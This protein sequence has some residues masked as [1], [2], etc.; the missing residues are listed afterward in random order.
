MDPFRSG[1]T[2]DFSFSFEPRSSVHGFPD[3][4]KV[5]AEILGQSIHATFYKLDG[6]IPNASLSSQVLIKYDSDSEISQLKTGN[7]VV[8]SFGISNCI[9]FIS[10]FF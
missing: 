7:L 5:N 8:L 9:I 6:L 1:L 4:F 2:P 10:L 3:N